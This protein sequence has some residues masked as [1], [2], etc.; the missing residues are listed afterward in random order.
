MVNDGSSDYS[1]SIIDKYAQSDIR[2]VGISLDKSSGGPAHPRNI[3]IDNAKALKMIL[4]F[5]KIQNIR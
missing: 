2:I 5:L 4:R 1:S 3:G